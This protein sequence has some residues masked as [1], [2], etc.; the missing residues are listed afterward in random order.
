MTL[1]Q[2]SVPHVSQK[3]LQAIKGILPGKFL[4]LTAALLSLLWVVVYRALS[5][6]V[7]L[8]ENLHIPL[9]LSEVITFAGAPAV[10][11]I[12]LVRQWYVVRN[13]NA[14][15]L[16]A[17]KPKAAK[18]SYFKIGP[19]NS[20]PEDQEQFSRS[21]GAHSKVAKWI[22]QSH[23][24]TLYLT[25]DSGAG[26][27]SLLMASV[28]P[29]LRN[30]GW[31]IIEARAW[32]DPFAQIRALGKL[33]IADVAIDNHEQIR[34][35]L[36]AAKGK[37]R[38][39]LLIL[40]QF[41][42]FL[43]LGEETKINDFARFITDLEV[44]PIKGVSTLLAL[45]SDYQA[46]LDN[47]GFPPFRQGE[48][49]MQVGR[50]TLAAAS[51][52]IRKSGLGLQEKAIEQIVT[53]AAL[54]D[55]SPGIVRPITL[56]VVGYVLAGG[57]T[58]ADSLD[59][60]T[61]VRRYIEQVVDGDATRDIARPVLE[62]LVTEQGTKQPVSEAMIVDKTRLSRGEVRAVLNSLS[63]AALARALDPA[64]GIWE[65]THD[66]VARA[67]M[68]Y[69]GRSRPKLRRSAVAFAAP[70]LFGI[71]VTILLGTIVVREDYTSKA[72]VSVTPTPE[73]KLVVDDYASVDYIFKVDGEDV[74]FESL[75]YE[76]RH[77]NGDVISRKVDM[78]MLGGGFKVQA[79][80]IHHF[81]DNINAPPEICHQVY[82]SDDRQLNFEYR[83]NGVDMHG[84]K[85][86]VI[87][88]LRLVCP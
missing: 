43:I 50:F 15:R 47:P 70:V 20:S 60:G 77:T 8:T 75:D 33:T 52:F 78:R 21:D 17:M 13:V 4:G 24:A 22:M 32:Q 71:L 26:K 69:L 5:L 41:E 87:A 31:K 85:I 38:R 61:L 72:S 66:F 36:I 68:R 80:Q 54:M 76:F 37:S 51:T 40:D 27:S 18:Q 55:D 7:Y 19:Y 45:R 73:V 49:W 10:V 53:S 28:L 2:D 44:N 58:R 30:E 12:Y 16:L 34:Q 62:I 25:G 3:D 48:N 14:L 74:Q 46:M 83:F 59:A 81:L 23:A 9:L 39:L 79:G 35:F 11:V 1:L 86:S 42:E 82:S 6:S 67:V 57:Q 88:I 64:Q 56:N 65:L 84:I 63:A 29:L